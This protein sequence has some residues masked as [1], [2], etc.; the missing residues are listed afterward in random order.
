MRYLLCAGF[1]IHAVAHLVGVLV[2]WRLI[3]LEEAP[4]KTT[5]LADSLD[6]GDLGMKV[7]GLFWLLGVVGFSAAG[8]GVLLGASW[9]QS[10]AVYSALFSLIL[11]V[12]GWPES[13]YGVFIN[14]AI[15]VFLLF[16]GARGWLPV[17]GG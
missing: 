10:L 2:P 1:L 8:L 13:R 14:I 7:V 11:S 17:A 3:E 12:F 4:Y 6:V 9:W 16:G 15:V 5:Q